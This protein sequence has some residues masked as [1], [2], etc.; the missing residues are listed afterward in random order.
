MALSHLDHPP[1]P[2]VPEQ[3]KS[4]HLPCLSS[5]PRPSQ[6]PCSF[7][8][9]LLP[10]HLLGGGYYAGAEEAERRDPGLALPSGGQTARSH[11]SGA[12]QDPAECGTG[13]RRGQAALGRGSCPGREGSRPPGSGGPALAWAAVG[14]GRGG[15]PASPAA[16]PGQ[17][18]LCLQN[19]R[20]V[21]R[22][23]DIKPRVPPG[24]RASQ[25]PGDL[26][27]SPVTQRDLRVRA[28]VSWL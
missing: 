13:R 28:R 14:A 12:G 26:P 15:G 20:K 6:G 23:T 1:L 7:T 4:L 27:R 8:P 11:R 25:R 18:A 2:L 10:E 9:Q 24:P 17:R 5:A 16:R 22:A 3:R 21:P 19:Q